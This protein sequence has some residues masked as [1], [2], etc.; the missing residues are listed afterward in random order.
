M[1]SVEIPYAPRY[2]EVH[3]TLE[4]TRFVVLVAHRRFGKTVAPTVRP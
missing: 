3:E 4:R 1:E 2:P